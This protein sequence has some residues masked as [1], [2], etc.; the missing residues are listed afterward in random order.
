MRSLSLVELIIVVNAVLLSITVVTVVFSIPIQISAMIVAL[1]YI[2][3]PVG[4]LKT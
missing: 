2:T 1:D 3:S 4:G